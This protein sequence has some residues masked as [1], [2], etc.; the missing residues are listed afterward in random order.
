MCSDN[1]I[2]VLIFI[3]LGAN[4]VE[5]SF[6]FA[7]YVSSWVKCLFM[8]FAYFLMGLLSF[9]VEFESSLYIVD[10]SPLSDM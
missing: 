2:V 9:T 8:S 1:L 3:F 6:M 10:I 7:T 4:D 5:N